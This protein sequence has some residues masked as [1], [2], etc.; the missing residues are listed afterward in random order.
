MNKLFTFITLSILS[1]VFL[2]LTSCSK[3]DYLVDGGL[4]NAKVDMSTYDYL[5]GHPQGLF[6]TLIHIIDHFGLKEEINQSET[7]FAPTNYSIRRYYQSKWNEL[8]AVDENATFSLEQ[9]LETIHVDS[10]K[11]YIY[12]TQR[13]DLSVASTTYSSITNAGNLPGFACHKQLQPAGQWSFQPIYYLFYVKIRGEVDQV[14]DDGTVITPEDD[15][16][17]LRVRCQTQ[18][19]ETSTGTI[20]NVLAN[21]HLFISDFNE[22]KEYVEPDWGTVLEYDIAFPYDAGGYTGGSVEIDR[23]ALAAAFGLTVNQVSTLFGSQVL[24]YGTNSDGTLDPNST[25][26]APGHWFN[27]E[28]NV[29]TWGATAVLFSE[30]NASAFSFNIGQ[31]PGQAVKG[32]EYVIRQSL[33][34]KDDNDDETQVTFRFNVTIE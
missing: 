14:G 2:G 21:N 26:T 11:A 30:Y 29:T 15:F 24:F 28:G 23:D 10:L 31:Y 19:I 7:F 9:M 20:I 12:P 18:G 3:A 5:A 1:G 27:V 25:A 4:H 22:P 8:R 13:Y 16:A 34:Y 17:D 32:E 33:V 6:D